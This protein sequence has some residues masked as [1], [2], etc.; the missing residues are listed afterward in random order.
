MRWLF[1]NI[2]LLKNAVDLIKFGHMT[3]NIGWHSHT[4]IAQNIRG[5]RFVEMRN[6]Q[7]ANFAYSSYLTPVNCWDILTSII[8]KIRDTPC[9]CKVPMLGSCVS[10]GFNAS[11]RYISASPHP[12][13]FS[14]ALVISSRHT[15]HPSGIYPVGKLHHGN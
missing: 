9:L 2:A 11:V 10:I 6:P 4:A 1:I 15:N 3:H 12:V 8:W 5:C 13:C 14:P 7:F